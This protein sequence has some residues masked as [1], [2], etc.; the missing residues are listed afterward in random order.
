MTHL[1]FPFAIDRRG[2][3]EECPTPDHVAQLVEQVLYTAPGERVNRPTFGTD[4]SQL[5]FKGLS[6]EFGS[7]VQALIKGSLNQWLGD[8]IAVESVQVAVDGPEAT[9]TVAYTEKA[10]QTKRQLVFG[11]S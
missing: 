8:V 3:V 6:T 11:P 7:A 2:R 9:V 5:A 4:L 1:A 10:T